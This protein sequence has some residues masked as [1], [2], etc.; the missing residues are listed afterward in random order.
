[1]LG[2]GQAAALYLSSSASPQRVLNGEAHTLLS[3]L[4]VSAGT[5]MEMA[6]D[7]GSASNSRSDMGGL[8]EV[9]VLTPCVCVLRW[10]VP[11]PNAHHPCLLACFVPCRQSPNCCRSPAPPLAHRPA[12]LSLQPQEES[13]VLDYKLVLMNKQEEEM[14]GL[15]HVPNRRYSSA[16]QIK[17]VGEWAGDRM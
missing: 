3:C 4:L 11:I 5:S 15:A 6:G 8:Q 12:P 17:T 1:L 10:H 7:Q 9:G 2:V 14:V 13:L 16:I